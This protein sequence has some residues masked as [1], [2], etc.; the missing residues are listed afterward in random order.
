MRTLD[1]EI[2]LLCC[3]VDLFAAR[4]KARLTKCAKRGKRGWDGDCPENA[5]LREIIGDATIT[6]HLSKTG[7]AGKAVDIANRAMMVW[8]RA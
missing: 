5:L 8:Y 2:W 4:M 3:A 6:G 7:K 1:D